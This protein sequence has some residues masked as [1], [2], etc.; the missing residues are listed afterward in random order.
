MPHAPIATWRM[1]WAEQVHRDSEFERSRDCH[2]WNAMSNKARKGYLSGFRLAYRKAAVVNSDPIDKTVLANEEVV[3]GG[4][5][6]CGSSWRRK[7]D[8][9]SGSFA[10]PRTPIA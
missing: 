7:G 6:R 5:W 4:G 1:N 10:S 2:R 3:E 9:S 8:Y